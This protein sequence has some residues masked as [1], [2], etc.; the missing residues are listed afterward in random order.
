MQK[1][2]VLIGSGAYGTVWRPTLCP[3]AHPDREIGKLMSYD[4]ALKEHAKMMTLRGIPGFDQENYWSLLYKGYCD[5]PAVPA[6]V[7]AANP[8]PAVEAALATVRARIVADA[9]IQATTAAG[10]P[11]VSAAGHPVM[12]RWKVLRYD[13]GGRTLGATAVSVLARQADPDF[14]DHLLAFFRSLHSL[15]YGVSRMLF[16]YDIVHRDINPRN[17]VCEMAPDGRVR[18]FRLI[19][20]GLYID[21]DDP[22]SHLFIADECSYRYWPL[23]SIVTSTS[24]GILELTR[25]NASLATQLFNG[26]NEY[27]SQIG[28]ADTVI[29][30]QGAVAEMRAYVMEQAN[31]ILQQDAFAALRPHIGTLADP[32]I[33]DV[34]RMNAFVLAG[35]DPLL[36]DFDTELRSA[37]L[38]RTDAFSVGITLFEVLTQFGGVMAAL[39]PAAIMPIA[40]G[41]GNP[42]GSVP[43]YRDDGTVVQV[44]PPAPDGLNFFNGYASLMNLARQLIL[45]DGRQRLRIQDAEVQFAALEGAFLQPAEEYVEANNANS[46]A[47]EGEPNLSNHES[48]EEM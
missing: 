9:A 40:I 11:I 33:F 43:F 10:V 8:N 21:R 44:F 46:V 17:I 31:R 35:G 20:F 39:A 38:F 45:P 16:T 2:G 32:M 25:S 23:E 41:P 22:K 42:P 12:K 48:D 30:Q 4:E 37:L 14:A 34:N 7:A 6:D 29:N 5:V 18:R 36:N 26:R 3:V 27:L 47:S 13:Y 1:G 19:D 15:F 24:R 28:R